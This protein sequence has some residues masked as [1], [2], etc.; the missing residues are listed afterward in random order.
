MEKTK[1]K[2]REWVKTF[3]IIFLVV[4]LI[5]T[6]FSNTIMNRSLPEVAAQYTQ[7]GS[8]N[9]KIRG[10]GQVSANETYDVTL[11]QTRK[12]RS[13]MVKVGDQV[14]TGDTLFVLEPNDSEELKQAQESLAQMELD[15]QKKLITLSNDNSTE[16]REVKNSATPM[17]R[18]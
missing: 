11:N 1:A 18:L 7:S 10:T 8:I 9:A 14:S 13:V 17:K 2:K 4:M 12:I 5:L 15:Y 16:N 6:F 3:V